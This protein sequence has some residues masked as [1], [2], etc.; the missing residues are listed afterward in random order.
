MSSTD[1]GGSVSFLAMLVSD[2]VRFTCCYFSIIKISSLP[3]VTNDQL[4]I[5]RFIFEKQ[6]LWLDIY[7]V[8]V[9]HIRCHAA[10][11]GHCVRTH[12]WVIQSYLGERYFWNV[13][14]A[15]RATRIGLY[16]SGTY[17]IKKRTGRQS[18]FVLA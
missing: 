12:A 7:K 11:T 1:D 4:S 2:V 6:V 10:C 17:T 8:Y 14:I 15:G 18:F 5:W 16:Q 13:S 3:K 9:C